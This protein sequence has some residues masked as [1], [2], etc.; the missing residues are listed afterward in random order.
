[1]RA[2]STSFLVACSVLVLTRRIQCQD[3]N[4]C[5]K[6]IE[7]ECKEDCPTT[8]PE[9]DEDRASSTCVDERANQQSNV[10]TCKLASLENVVCRPVCERWR[11][12]HLQIA[13]LVSVYGC[14]DRAQAYC[15]QTP[16][17]TPLPAGTTDPLGK[18]P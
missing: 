4:S 12:I 17:A 16:P 11:Q 13:I 18:A 7:I 5:A 6:A 3:V 8:L 1:M 15:K 10:K 9:C 2:A 14:G